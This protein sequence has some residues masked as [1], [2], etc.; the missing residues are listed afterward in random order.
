[1]A[2]L[3]GDE[4]AI[5]AAGSSGLQEVAT[6]AQKILDL[7][8]QPFFCQEKEVWMTTSIGIAFFPLEAEDAETLVNNADE[9]MYAA[10][11]AGRNNYQFFSEKLCRPLRSPV[12]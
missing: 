3:S 7:F 9:A 2:R 4:F 10:K 8:R 1:V 6:V 5:I 11:A 12:T